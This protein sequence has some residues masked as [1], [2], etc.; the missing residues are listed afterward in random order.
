MICV[1]LHRAQNTSQ[2]MLPVISARHYACIMLLILRTL[3]TLC[4]PELQ[5]PLADDQSDDRL[6]KLE[7]CLQK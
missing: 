7:T 4:H 6:E 5:D 1:I 3:P 2:Q